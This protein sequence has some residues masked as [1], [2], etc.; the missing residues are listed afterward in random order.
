MV[1][2]GD[3]YTIVCAVFDSLFMVLPNEMIM[4][5]QA[6]DREREKPKGKQNA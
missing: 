6:I 3:C 2:Y 5:N 1:H 4:T